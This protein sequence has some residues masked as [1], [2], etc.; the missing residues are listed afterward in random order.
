M[1]NVNNYFEVF[2]N[3]V[4]DMLTIKLTNIKPNM[5]GKIYNDL[6]QMIKS[7]PLNA[8]K[9]EVNTSDMTPGVYTLEVWEQNN[10]VGVTKIMKE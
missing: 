10:R 2:P 7:L 5:V 4:K 6:G 3:P 1:D 8:E 9:S